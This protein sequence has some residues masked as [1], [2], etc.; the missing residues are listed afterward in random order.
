MKRR[1]GE[2]L[3]RKNVIDSF[4][5][6]QALNIQRRRG[7][8]PLG[9]IALHDKLISAEN[10]LNILDIQSNTGRRFGD[11]ALE[12]GYLTESQINVLCKKQMQLH[13]HIGEILVEMNK[14]KA[15][16]LDRL[17][18][19]FNASLDDNTHEEDATIYE[20]DESDDIFIYSDIT[21][22][23]CGEKS[24]QKLVKSSLYEV[25]EKDID[26]KP[27]EYKWTSERAG[28]CYPQLYDIWQCPKCHFALEHDDFEDP[29][30]DI[31]PSLHNFRKK[32]TYLFS[33]DHEVAG[34]IS[35]LSN[36]DNFEDGCEFVVAIRRYLQAICVYSKL[37]IIAEQEGVP[38]AQLCLHLAWIYRDLRSANVDELYLSELKK[39]KLAIDH[40]WIKAPL[41]ET[42]ALEMALYYYD[43]AV[44]QSMSLVERGVEHEVLQL[45][46]RIY[47]RLGRIREARKMLL[48]TI[49]NGN[50]QIA[51]YKTK[52]KPENNEFNR[53]HNKEVLKDLCRINA[54]VKETKALL[55]YC[56]TLK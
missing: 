23:V 4:A 39:I 35:M 29:T 5:L 6:V 15:D 26:L 30:K 56:S 9:E 40:L 43:I 16:E 31:P 41:N 38:L 13:S 50:K 52:L 12:F 25:G 42:A 2:F 55:E 37:P 8:I 21:C 33:E 34:V 10:L 7:L 18:A 1:F 27:I 11:I 49:M 24:A 44:Y 3:I 14:I 20:A 46:G 22:P 28:D 36:E 48:D 17:L 54:F 32:V 19:E 53:L 47:I 51:N 45:M